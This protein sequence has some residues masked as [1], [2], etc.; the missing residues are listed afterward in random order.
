MGYREMTWKEIRRINWMLMQLKGTGKGKDYIG[1][2]AARVGK[3]PYS[4]L[5]KVPVRIREVLEEEIRIIKDDKPKNP[6]EWIKRAFYKIMLK[7]AIG[8]FDEVA[9][10]EYKKENEQTKNLHKKR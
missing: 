10:K 2:L 1:T 5:E 3:Y 9:V 4:E 7:N 8:L 6:K